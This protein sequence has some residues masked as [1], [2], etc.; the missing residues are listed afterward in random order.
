MNVEATMA[1]DANLIQK[2]VNEAIAYAEQ[3]KGTEDG[4]TCNFD[5]C[6]IRVP[7]MRKAAAE[8]IAGTFL[9]EHGFHGRRL[10]LRG[11]QGQANCRTTMAEAQREFLQKNYPQLEV[12]MYYQMD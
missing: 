4:G 12:G 3:F 2:A 10:Q 6:Y 9:C 5:S 11:T 7:G 1:H 8:G